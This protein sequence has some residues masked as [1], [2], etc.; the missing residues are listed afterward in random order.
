V[1]DELLLLVGEVTVL[2]ARPEVVGPLQSAALAAPH[3]P[4]RIH[5]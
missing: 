5:R 2:D 3:Q 1:D 4:S